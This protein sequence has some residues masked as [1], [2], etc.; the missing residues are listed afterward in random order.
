MLDSVQPT[1]PIQPNASQATPRQLVLGVLAGVLGTAVFLGGILF[2]VNRPDWW[3]GFAAASV[4]AFLA[5]GVSLVP[6]VIGVRRGGAAVVQM[7]MAST[8]LRA[9]VA[10]G[11]C[12]LAGGVG[13][14]PLVPTLALVIPY[15]LAL[16]A[17]ETAC[18]AR[19]LKP[20]P[21]I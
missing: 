7:F 2:V 9:V 6:L 18:L 21:K 5:A 13:K 17:V 15:Y 11:I 19:G 8:G 4:A 14:F 1:L 10:L 16:L 3:R 20:S 12:A